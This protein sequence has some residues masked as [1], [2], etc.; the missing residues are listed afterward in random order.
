MSPRTGGEAKP[1]ARLHPWREDLAAEELRG[2]VDA[3]RFAVGEGFHVA[4]G[5]ADLRR[6]PREDA[7]LDSQLLL[8]EGFRVYDRA[9]GWAWGQAV[10]DGYVGYMAERCLGRGWLTA[11]HRVRALRTFLYARADLK[12]P[13]LLSAGMNAKVAV[14]ERCGRFVRT[15]GGL[16]VFAGHLGAVEER[17]ADYVA[18]AE[19]LLG[20]P[21]L[22][23][24]RDALGLDC[25][26][27]VQMA[28]EWAGIAC[29]RDADMQEAA[30]GEA[31]DFGGFDAGVLRRGDLVFWRGHVGILRDGETLLHASAHDMKVASEPLRQAAERIRAV[32]GEIR[33]V[34]R[35]GREGEKPAR[36]SKAS[37]FF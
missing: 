13:V 15:E 37:G 9:D 8:G 21:Y 32:E 5:C 17:C 11:T 19:D 2:R 14:A 26:A 35:V 30:L 20:V 18:V 28:L 27:L 34:R 10:L 31:I 25:S 24:G 12:A 29:P 1:D 22:W 7:P 33:C 6:A 36:W 16:Y 4:V 23:G 3:P